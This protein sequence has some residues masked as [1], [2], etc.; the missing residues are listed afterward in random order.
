MPLSYCPA[1][2]EGDKVLLFCLKDYPGHS[3]EAPGI[4]V[5][6]QTAQRSQSGCV[7]VD[8]LYEYHPLKVPI[9][10][11]TIMR[12]LTAQEAR[13][14]MYPRFKANWLRRIGDLSAKRL[15]LSDSRWVG[16]QQLK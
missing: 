2:G 3:W 12:C 15:G 13:Q 4:G 10:R 16:G 9:R 14:L 8:I 6:N 7:Y 1:I 5:V 11:E